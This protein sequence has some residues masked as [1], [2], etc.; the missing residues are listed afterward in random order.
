VDDEPQVLEGLQRVLRSGFDVSVSTSGQ[1]ALSRLEAGE[2]FEVVVSDMRMPVMNGAALLF[3][4]RRQAPDTVRVLLT[5]HS[6]LESAIA[7]VNEGHIFRFLTKPCPPDTLSTTLRAATLQYRLVTGERVLLEQTLVGS[8][9]ALTEVLALTHPEAFGPAT[10]QHER[11]RAIAERL[12]IADAWHVEVASM[13]ASVGFVVLPSDVLVKLNTGAPLDDAE[14]AMLQRVPSVVERILSNIPRLENVRE[15]LKHLG[16]PAERGAVVKA[17]GL[18]APIGTRVLR[19]VQDLGAAEARCGDLERALTEVVARRDQYGDN[20]LEAVVAVCR[21][22]QPEIRN[23]FV[24]EF[25]VGMVL[26]EEVKTDAG[27]V[28]VARGQRVTP[29][30]LERLKNFAQRMKLSEPIRC[31]VPASVASQ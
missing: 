29:Q 16:S 13:L 21:P 11:A 1:A 2:T 8:V 7:A 4:F 25:S 30:L 3:E 27:M 24:N 9:R 18:G 23:L 15:V 5:G 14:R 26:V 17:S 31:E 19:A 12:G 6:D 10:R 20:V 28:L 22:S